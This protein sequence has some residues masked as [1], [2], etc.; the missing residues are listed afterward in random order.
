MARRGQ[1]AYHNQSA[2]V[3]DRREHEGIRSPR[4]VPAQKIARAPSQHSRQ[5]VCSRREWKRRGHARRGYH[6]APCQ[7]LHLDTAARLN[8]TRPIISLLSLRF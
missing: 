7:F 6:A 8:E 5:T 2:Q 1:R 4:R 3:H